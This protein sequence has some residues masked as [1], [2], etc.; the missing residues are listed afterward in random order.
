[1]G[2]N[3]NRK[4]T[5]SS[6]GVVKRARELVSPKEEISEDPVVSTPA[7]ELVV[8]PKKPRVQPSSQGQFSLFGLWRS[9]S[10]S[11]KSVPLTSNWG[12]L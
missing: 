12:L 2:K 9:A 5:A 3:T 4:Q 6:S 7:D 11:L 10:S 8:V 1:M